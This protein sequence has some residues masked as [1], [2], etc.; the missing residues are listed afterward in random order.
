MS[1]Y[2]GR[3]D[4]GRIMM[5]RLRLLALLVLVVAASFGVWN[6]FS[7]ER[8]SHTLRVQAESER[9]DLALRES[10]LKG[11]LSKLETDR[12]KE[13]T[14]REQYALAGQGEGLI[15]IVDEP[16]STPITATTTPKSWLQKFFSWW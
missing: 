15:V 14:L 8:E 10:D 16:T 12:G 7:K 13:Q 11:D 6:V 5:K 9:N 2:S 4:V 1:A 3:R